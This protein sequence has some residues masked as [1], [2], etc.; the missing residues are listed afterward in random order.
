MG[1]HRLH[2]TKYALVAGHD[3]A[4]NVRVTH[5]GQQGAAVV[6]HT[7]K[8]KRKF[9]AYICRNVD[10]KRIITTVPC[11]AANHPKCARKSQQSGRDTRY[12]PK[13]K[14]TDK[15]ASLHG[16]RTRRSERHR[17]AK[18]KQAN[19]K[20]PVLRVLAHSDESNFERGVG[21]GG[22]SEHVSFPF[23]A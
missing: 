2:N 11:V 22:G 5:V 8:R 3:T 12:F 15:L 17:I 7:R 13:T 1:G 9:S 4:K 23:N 18:N 20:L 21:C 14:E 19:L 10:G 6:L 16:L